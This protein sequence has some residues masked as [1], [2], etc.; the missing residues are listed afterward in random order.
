MPL[1]YRFKA[2]PYDEALKSA[3]QA[4]PLKA[5]YELVLYLKLLEEE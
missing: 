2:K 3:L 4:F 5:S 1:E